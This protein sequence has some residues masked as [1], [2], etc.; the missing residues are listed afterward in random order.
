MG[1]LSKVTT[2]RR[3]QTV[4]KVDSCYHKAIKTSFYNIQKEKK[5]VYCKNIKQGMKALF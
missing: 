4:I 5:Y 3:H 2:H 1:Q